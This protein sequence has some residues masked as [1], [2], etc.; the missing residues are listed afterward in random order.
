M[1]RIDV[2]NP[3]VDPLDAIWAKG[4]RNPWRFSFDRG[5]GDL[6]I[7][8]VGQNQFE[9]INVVSAPVSTRS[10]GTVSGRVLRSSRPVSRS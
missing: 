6:Y 1:Y 8:D 7:G 9:E 5:T 2:D 4:V 3:P 10:E